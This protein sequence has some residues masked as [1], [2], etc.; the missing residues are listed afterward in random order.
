MEV[1]VNFGEQ[2]RQLI[3]QLEELPVVESLVKQ[4]QEAGA[5][6]GF[7]YSGRDHSRL[8]VGSLDELHQARSILR[9]LFNWKDE[10]FHKFFSCGQVIVTY[11]P[12]DTELPFPFKIW[13]ENIPERFPKELLGS[14]QLVES[15]NK[16]YNIVCPVEE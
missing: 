10:L 14:C 8:S 11:Q 1:S 15:T 4:L 16:Y 12:V 6:G 2:R 5:P 13:V 3:E 7:V 9:K